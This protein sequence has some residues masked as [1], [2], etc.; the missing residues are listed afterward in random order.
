MAAPAVAWRPGFPPS[1]SMVVL[2][3]LV[4]SLLAQ[5]MGPAA[6]AAHLRGYGRGVL[7][8]R[9]PYTYAHQGQ[10][11]AAGRCAGGR[12]QSP[13]DFPADA[14]DLSVTG[15]FSYGYRLN[16]ATSPVEFVNTGSTYSLY[17]SGPGSGGIW[18]KGA[19]YNLVCVNAHARSEHTWA[20]AHTAAELHLVHQR[21]DGDGWL[22]AA[23]ALDPVIQSA[24]ALQLAHR[25][26]AP[27]DGVADLAATELAVLEVPRLPAVEAFLAATQPPPP[28]GK[29]LLPPERVGAL[30][31]NGLLE[32]GAFFDYSGSLTAPPCAEPV[33]WL[34]RT[35]PLPISEEQVRSLQGLIF[36]LTAGSGNSRAAAPLAGRELSVL[37]ATWEAPP[38]PQAGV[39]SPAGL[40]STERELSVRR[41][42]DEAMRTADV[43]AEKA[44]T[45]NASA[46]AWAHA[47]AR[48]LVVPASLAKA[49]GG[50]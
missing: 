19:W 32:G 17:L 40:G 38:L 48:A 27:A 29:V 9:L 7:A 20:G 12:E 23:V 44:F 15:S 46:T 34:V 4:A 33:A 39:G 13:I 21:H 36:S 2:R 5:L 35:Q 42:A 3:W 41:Q 26:A 47:Q 22:V 37:Q 49:P 14:M 8:G 28:G 24:S 11:W 30:N 25:V 1:P 43:A 16:A 10:D 45:L 6:G 31:L 18:H 50:L